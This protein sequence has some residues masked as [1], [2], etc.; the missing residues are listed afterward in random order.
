MKDLTGKVFG[1]LTVIR[2]DSIKGGH[3]MWLC[4]CSCGV[5]KVIRG[6]HVTSGQTKS[7]G[8][9]IQEKLIKRNTT[10]GLSKI[11]KVMWSRWNEIISRTTFEKNKNYHHY[12]GRGIKMCDEWR[13][14]FLTFLKDMGEPP[15]DGAEI[16]RIDNDGN[17]SKENCRWVTRQQNIMNRR[18]SLNSSSKYKGV[19]F[20]KQY[21]TWMAHIT[22]NKKIYRIGLFDN[23]EDAGLAYNEKAKELFGE[24]AY[25]NKIPLTP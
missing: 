18:G 16:D 21:N 11:N 6:S 17:Y 9:I 14:D 3:S 12:G 1:E 22:L 19:I 20:S 10:H 5:E 25:L 8:H 4:L 13:N 7:C 24:Y 23:E 2:K 15:F